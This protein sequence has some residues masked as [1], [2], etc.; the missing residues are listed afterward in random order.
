MITFHL[1]TL[2]IAEIEEFPRIDMRTVT[3]R[4]N[5]GIK[6]L[7]ALYPVFYQSTLAIGVM[8]ILCL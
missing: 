3:A 1:T 8:V 4:G 7:R 2:M 5:S 6:Q